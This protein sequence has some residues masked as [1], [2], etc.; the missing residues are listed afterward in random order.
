VLTAVQV[1]QIK[2]PGRHANGNGLYLVV[3]PTGAKRW[4]LRTVVR[5]RRRDIG[6]GSAKLVQLAEARAT[7]AA[8]RKTARDGGDPIV[9]H[10]RPKMEVPTFAEAAH[11][12]YEQ[13]AR[14]W[15]NPKHAAQWI[16][17]LAR[18][19]FPHF[20][21]RRVDEVEQSDVLHALADLAHQ[22]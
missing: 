12:V 14:A 2:K 17:T 6:L 21:D 22:T 18:H 3:E 16:S 19:A 13:H 7:A 15:R 5:G 1:R 11:I 10:R 9:E 20:G 8:Y 4:V